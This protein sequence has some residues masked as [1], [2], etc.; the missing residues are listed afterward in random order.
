MSIYS[1]PVFDMAARQFEK[2]AD[3]LDMPVSERDRLLYPKRTIT[4]SVP[5]HRD[6]G[7]VHE[8]AI[9]GWEPGEIRIAVRPIAKAQK[10]ERDAGQVQPRFWRVHHP[11]QTG[12]GQVTP[13]DLVRSTAAEGG[14][15]LAD[16]GHPSTLAQGVRQRR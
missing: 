13:Q 14:D 15:K 8:P 12:K 4:V 10:A 3:H 9:L 5:V 6:D 7:T 16:A 1:G 2:V 11:R